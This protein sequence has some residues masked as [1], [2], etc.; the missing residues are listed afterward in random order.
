MKKQEILKVISDARSAHEAWID[1]GPFIADAIN[2]DGLIE[3]S[4]YDESDLY[5]WL[6]K[7]KS[8]I[9]AFEWFKELEQVH[10]QAHYS[11]S[12]LFENATRKYN[13]KTRDELLEEFKIV[14]TDVVDFNNKLD[15]IEDSISKMSDSVYLDYV[16]KSNAVSRKFEVNQDKPSE[17]IEEQSDKQITTEA[18]NTIES[19]NDAN[20]ANFTHIE[21]SESETEE[22]QENTI[23][24]KPLSNNTDEM[25]TIDIVEFEDNAES[26][27]QQDTSAKSVV[28]NIEAVEQESVID[29]AKLANEYQQLKT[30]LNSTDTLEKHIALKEQ[31]IN[32]LIK[33]KELSEQ[34]LSHL[35]ETQKLSQ[36]GL[37]QLEQHLQLKQEENELEQ[38][39]SEKLLETNTI[40]RDKTKQQLDQIEAKKQTLKNELSELEQEN[41]KDVLIQ[42]EYE[43]S[44]QIEK[45]FDSLKNN[46]IIEVDELKKQLSTKNSDLMQL[47]QQV[48]TLEAEVTDIENDI[49]IK[50]KGIEDL[51]EKENSKNQ[52]R[53]MQLEATQ[54][55]IK[56]RNDAISVNNEKLNVLSAESVEAQKE[57]DGL[58]EKFEKM[59]K[60]IFSIADINNAEIQEIEAQQVSKRQKYAD[61][62]K[63]KVSKQ[64][65]IK[66]IESH[67]EDAEKTLD[68][69]KAE[70][71]NN[72]EKE[73]ETTN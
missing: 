45:Q 69:L 9:S 34:E 25:K 63:Q 65:E 36:Q 48:M 11:Y 70:L 23:D 57:L 35:E 56:D 50:V 51:E 53:S 12:D 41:A 40:E 37:D 6:K 14:K 66:V 68:Q 16:L 44:P 49:E 30:G 60:T 21:N 72:S 5:T 64:E 2:L 26:K 32:R 58:N 13:P 59:K 38:L 55:K 17:I 1:Q 24:S 47:K 46:K 62:D 29:N 3:P 15:Q 28:D 42:E 27:N 7:N 73:L 52:E 39:D 4:S 33:E 43:N 19:V 61:I 67:L 18:D 10:V 71:N 8:S 20:T 54:K 22:K 31:N